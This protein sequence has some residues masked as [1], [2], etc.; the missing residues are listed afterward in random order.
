MDIDTGDA[1][2]DRALTLEA[3]LMAAAEDVLETRTPGEVFR[4]LVA[5]MDEG[6]LYEATHRLGDAL[7][8]EL[9][10]AEDALVDRLRILLDE[11][12]AQLEAYEI[13]EILVE[14]CDIEASERALRAIN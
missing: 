1:E 5:A 2:L 10:T 13:L 11:A 4:I 6:T 7:N 8:R 9:E 14:S 3:E 12:E